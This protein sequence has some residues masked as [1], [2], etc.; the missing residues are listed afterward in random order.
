MG[1]LIS[2]IKNSWSLISESL[3]YIPAVI[4]ILFVIGIILLL[5]IESAYITE[6]QDLSFMYGGTAEEAKAIIQTLLSAM[7]TT[8]MLVLS[9]TMVMLSL[10]ASQLG[11]RL[12][13]IFMK[14][15]TTKNY[16]GCFFGSIALCFVM[17]AFLHSFGFGS[18][19]PTISISLTFLICFINLFALLSYVNHVIRSSVADNVINQVSEEVLE[20]IY[21]LKDQDKD[22]KLIQHIPGNI[23][24][25]SHKYSHKLC[26]QK[27]GYI[28]IINYHQL[29]DIAEEYNLFFEL[30]KQAGDYIIAGE[31]IGL[32]YS[33]NSTLVSEINK[34]I[35]N[36][37][38]I[39]E[40]QTE[41]QDIEYLIRHLIEIGLR[42]LSPGINDNFTAIAVINSLAGIL[43]KIFDYKLPTN[44]YKDNQYIIRITT[45][46]N[47]EADIIFRAFSQIRDAG[48][49]KPDILESLIRSLQ[50]LKSIAKD[51]DRIAAVELQLDYIQEH[52]DEFF[53]NKL[54]SQRLSV[55]LKC[56]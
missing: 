4:S 42:A 35:N 41:T 36:L 9:I 8:T 24:H 20:S 33:E 12:I 5:S 21:K 54:E 14:M 56:R 22:K 11:P 15:Q 37:Y 32:I 48:K 31:I 52:I 18:Q 6:L 28:Q 43:A 55:L 2:R 46:Y 13:K 23:S 16:I 30:S 38:D 7:I 1:N 53:H 10:S 17:L 47:R 34:K 25:E 49:T 3:F 44:I 51:S 19:I 29:V 50:S 45:Q 39:G 26:L 27:T 40:R